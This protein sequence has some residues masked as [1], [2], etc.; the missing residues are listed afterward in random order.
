MQF[1]LCC[2]IFKCNA[3][4]IEETNQEPNPLDEMYDLFKRI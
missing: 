1:I 4:K 2:N 3:V